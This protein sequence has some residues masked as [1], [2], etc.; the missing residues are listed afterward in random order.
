LPFNTFFDGILA[1]GCLTDETAV[2]K[3]AVMAV[4]GDMKPLTFSFANDLA[5][6]LRYLSI[7]RNS[8]DAERSVSIKYTTVNAHK[9]QNFAD[10][11][12]TLQ[13]LMVANVR[14]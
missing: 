8:V 14:N 3:W 4:N 2:Y 10:A 6:R 9:C 5:V 13:V 12:L 7:T 11:N 1:A